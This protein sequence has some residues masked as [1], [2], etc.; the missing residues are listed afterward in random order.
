[1]GSQWS[2]L[3]ACGMPIYF[4]N[5]SCAICMASKAKTT[6]A[7]ALKEAKQAN[8]RAKVKE[9]KGTA[10]A[11]LQVSKKQAGINAEL[12]RIKKE[13]VADNGKCLACGTAHNLTLSHVISRKHKAF[14]TDP[15]NLVLLCMED[16][17]L[18]EHDKSTFA[19]YHP[20]AW[21]EKLE[22]AKQL[23]NTAYQKLILKRDN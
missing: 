9:R 22:R 23:D 10:T 1:M 16:H 19:L 18:F 2:G 5:P 15:L 12:S 14:V 11:I 17:M 7:T 6:R 4:N 21:N 3:C 20:L 8:V 13:L